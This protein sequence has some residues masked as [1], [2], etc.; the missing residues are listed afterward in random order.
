M[1]SGVKMAFDYWYY[2]GL[3]G[4]NQRLETLDAELE[5]LK[6]TRERNKAI[7][8]RDSLDG[9]YTTSNSPQGLYTTASDAHY[10][11]DDSR[12][13]GPARLKKPKRETPEEEEER[14]KQ[15]KAEQ[16]ASLSSIWQHPIQNP[17]DMKER[18]VYNGYIDK[19]LSDYVNG[20]DE[21]EED[22][23]DDI[24]MPDMGAPYAPNHDPEAVAEWKAEQARKAA[25]DAGKEK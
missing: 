22:F 19:R 17:V 14:L 16:N 7:R 8:A 2:G 23:D 12:W 13:N 21:D 4:M 9:T 1:A 18:N 10:V 5:Q 25:D 3:E 15:I 11:S 24:F 20:R 6:D